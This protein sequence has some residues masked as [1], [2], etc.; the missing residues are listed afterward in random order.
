MAVPPPPVTIGGAGGNTGRVAMI[1]Y[2]VQDVV[3]VY[4]GQTAAAN[5]PATRLAWRGIM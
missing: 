4:A 3:K 1:V 2:D 5:D